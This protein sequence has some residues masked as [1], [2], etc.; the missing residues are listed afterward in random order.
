MLQ[1][2]VRM[3][4]HGTPQGGYFLGFFTHDRSQMKLES[5]VGRPFNH[6]VL[7]PPSTLISSQL[8]AGTRTV[9]T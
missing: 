5:G 6:S 1:R 8:V 3:L 2:R 7:V 9:G 4:V